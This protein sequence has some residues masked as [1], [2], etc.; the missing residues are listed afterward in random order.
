[1]VQNDCTG[2]LVIDGRGIGYFCHSAGLLLLI[3]PYTRV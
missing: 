1:M 2:F 3:T